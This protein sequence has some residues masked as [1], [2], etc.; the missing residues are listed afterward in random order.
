MDNNF[1]SVLDMYLFE[2]NTLLEQLDEILLRAEKEQAFDKECIDEIFRIMHTIK[3]SSAMM[4]FNSIMTISHKV[5][6]LFYYIRENG[7]KSEYN[8]KLVTLVFKFTDFIK[9]EIEKIEQGESLTEDLKSFEKEIFDFLQVISGLSSDETSVTGETN[10][11]DSEELKKFGIKIF[12]D[13][14]CGMENLRAFFIVN[15]LEESGVEFIYEPKNVE[16]NPEAAK[17]IIKDGFNVYLKDKESLETSIGVV[18]GALNVKD[19]TVLEFECENKE[20]KEAK[21]VNEEIAVTKVTED[22]GKI[23]SNGSSGNDK[24]NVENIIE[25]IENAA[26]KN[27]SKNTEIKHSKQSLI[28]VNL[29]DR[30]SVV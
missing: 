21:E 9:G 22:I 20:A 2:A 10:V 8:E 1:D 4:Q 26:N 19:Y 5:E 18:K 6:D 7:I 30:K 29:S 23:S 15:Q 27:N 14:D 24:R 25:T 28:T 3:G 17:E 12:F 16:N 13:D 11:A